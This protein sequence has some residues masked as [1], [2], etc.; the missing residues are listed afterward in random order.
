MKLLR[1]VD[2]FLDRI[3]MYRLLLYFLLALEAIAFGLS[4]AG[5]LHYRPEAIVLSAS[6]LTLVCVASNELFAWAFKAPANAESAYIT[7]AI[8]ALIITPVISAEQILFFTAAG[9][10]AMASKYLLAI[11]KRHVFNP[12]AVAV[13]ITALAGGQA[14]SW[15]VGS[16]AML[17]YVV[18]GGLLV[19]RKVRRFTMI[20]AFLAAV[21]A[22]TILVNLAGGHDVLANLQKTALHSSLFFLAFVMLTEPLTSPTTKG[23]QIWYGFIA[24]ALFPPQLHIGS[25]YSAPELALL[26]ANVF[27]FITG[28][29]RR[30][31]P[32]FLRKEQI[33]PDL[34][35]FVFRQDKKV[36][37]KAGQYMEW[38][39]PHKKSDLRGVRRYFTLA[40]SPTEDTLRIGVR[41]YPKGSSFKRA[42]DTLGAGTPI[43]A[44]NLGGDFILPK[45]PAEKLAF[46]AGGIGI[47]PYRSMIKYLLD[48]GEKR[49]VTLLYSEV[50]AGELAY[51]D[52][53]DQAERELDLKTVYTLTGPDPPAGWQGKTGFLNAAMIAAEVPDYRERTFYISGSHTMVVAMQDALRSLGVP[54][55]RIKTDFFPGYA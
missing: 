40:S 10:L 30:L 43:A 7:A 9:G 4:L 33:A 13:T 47:T 5:V 51:T 1:V 37:Y 38:T 14:A 54:R 32:Q 46:I 45:N 12:A 28:F 20:F 42:L 26:V 31:T 55:R 29:K 48:T 2:H 53:F 22:S 8:L 50:S 44:G 23:K 16:T 3:T 24:G 21:W 17:P 27:A 25:V 52:V 18:I 39:L 49:V 35:D 36:R 6:L 41:F 15:W 34:A 19:A 11:H